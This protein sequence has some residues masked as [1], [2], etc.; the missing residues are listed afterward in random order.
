MNR[1]NLDTRFF[2]RKISVNFLNNENSKDELF[3]NADSFAM[4]FDEAWKAINLIKE[5]KDLEI[6][7]KIKLVFKKTKDHP[8]L[9]KDSSQA[10]KIALFRI[11]LLDLR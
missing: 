9:Q 2:G 7:E 4:C 3:N 10:Y 5:N 8:L 1:Q 11:R 6:E